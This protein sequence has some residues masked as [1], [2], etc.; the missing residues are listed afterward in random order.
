[1]IYK[2]LLNNEVVGYRFDTKLGKFDC[3]KDSL[4]E[5][6]EVDG[7]ILAQSDENNIFTKEDYC[8]NI[9]DISKSPLLKDV[10]LKVEGYSFGEQYNLYMFDKLEDLIKD[11]T[12]LN[13]RF[14]VDQLI[15]YLYKGIKVAELFG[16]RRTGKTVAMYQTIQG[17]LQKGV[18]VKEI[19]YITLYNGENNIDSN[20]ICG[21]CGVLFKLGVK[22]LFLDEITYVDGDLDFTSIFSDGY[23]GK[24]VVLAGTDSAVFL[25]PNVGAL[26]D[27]VYKINTTYISFKEFNYLYKDKNIMDYIRSGGLL[28]S[29]SFYIN[30]HNI[31]NIGYEEYSKIGIDYLSTSVIDNLFNSFDRYDFSDDYPVLYNIYMNGR[32][33]EIKTAIIKWIQNYSIKLVSEILSRTFKLHDAGVLASSLRSKYG[34]EE[35]IFPLNKLLQEKFKEKISDNK[36]LSENPN[37][38]FELKSFLYK[39]DCFYKIPITGEEYVLPIM[40]RYGLTCSIIKLL[41]DNYEYFSSLVDISLSAKDLADV[42]QSCIEGALLEE[43]IRIEIAKNGKYEGKFRDGRKEIDIITNDSLIE[44]KKSNKILK[45]QMRWLLNPEIQNKHKGKSLVLL[46]NCEDEKDIVCTEKDCLLS[47]KEGLE[48]KGSVI[49]SSLSKDIDNASTEEKTIHCRNISKYLSSIKPLIRK[50]YDDSLFD[51]IF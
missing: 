3:Y 27:R 18:D 9:P 19:A 46:T 14:F 12:N 37:F 5:N 8:N 48:L 16:V 25:K 32:K 26:Y 38:I 22:Y 23:V 31:D 47:I 10:L 39:I 11:Y 15:D 6:I 40:I 13:S 29:S 1:M 36:S 30:M 49:G 34:N 44:V 35:Y 2:I 17:L 43:V 45:Q 42:L 50:R 21:I 41:Y 28:L 33:N 7:G 4:Q 24:R 20:A 51:D